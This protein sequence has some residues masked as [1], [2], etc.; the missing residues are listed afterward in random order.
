M[1]RYFIE[2]P[3]V[4]ALG[5]TVTLTGE[6]AHHIVRVMRM[7]PEAKIE[8]VFPQRQAYV[9]QL[10]QTTPTVEARLMQAIT[11]NSELPVAVTIACGL[12]KK[13]KADWIVQKGTELGAQQFIFFASTYAVAKWDSKKQAK[14]LERLQKI[15]RD[16]ARQ[17]HRLL[18]PAVSYLKNIATLCE[19]PKDQGMIAYEEAGKS[20]ETAH[21]VKLSRQL[22]PNQ[23]IIGVFGPEGGFAPQE[24]KQFNEAGFATVGLGP[25]ILR[26]ETAPLYYLSALSTILELQTPVVQS[27]YS[28]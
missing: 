14:K 10:M 12:S 26:A 5:T 4:T 19:L 23:R 24:V 27:A 21:L 11:F 28:E 3:M 18:I 7:A 25:R 20:G 17:S 22:V 1:Q 13:D 15:A 6:I 9:A 2:T 8:L 16:A